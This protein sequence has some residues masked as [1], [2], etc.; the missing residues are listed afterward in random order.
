MQQIIVKFYY[1]V[2]QILLN[3][4]RELLCPTSGARQTGVA[5]S[6]FRM[7]VEPR[8]R[9]LPPPHPSGNQRLQRQFDGLLI[10]GISNARNMFSSICTTK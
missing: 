5:A 8:L 4:F 6:G 9:T 3:M 10:M 7:D 2:V 1:F